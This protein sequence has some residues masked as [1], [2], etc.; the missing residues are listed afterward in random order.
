VELIGCAGDNAGKSGLCAIVIVFQVIFN[1]VPITHGT[2]RRWS[3]EGNEIFMVI[4]ILG[5]FII[6]YFTLWI[7]CIVHM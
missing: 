5:Y 4:F 2:F 6:C 7:F 1:T 3:P